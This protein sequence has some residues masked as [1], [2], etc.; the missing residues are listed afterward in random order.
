MF[1]KQPACDDTLKLFGDEIFSVDWHTTHD[2]WGM[3]WFR[4][5]SMRCCRPLWQMLHAQISNS[6][7][8]AA[9]VP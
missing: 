5:V 8:L 9:E 1:V 3:V 6:S 4:G 7:L 2:G